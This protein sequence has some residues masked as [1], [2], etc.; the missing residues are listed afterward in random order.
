MIRRVQPINKTIQ[1]ARRR[2]AQMARIGKIKYLVIH[3]SASD[4]NETTVDEIKQWHLN[5]GYYDIGYHK[6]IDVNGLIHQGRPDDVMGAHCLGSNHFSLGIC[7]IG[8]FE[9]DHLLESDKQ[10]KTLIQTLATLCK[11]YGLTEQAIVPHKAL[12]NTACPGRNVNIQKIRQDV[13]RYL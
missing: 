10:Y 2:Q 9:E 11:R 1:V 7:L 6:I 13:K 4:R 12:Y 5:K 3:H 8:N